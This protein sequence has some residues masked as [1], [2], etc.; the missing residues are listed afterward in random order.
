MVGLLLWLP[1]ELEIDTQREIFEVRWQGIFD[2]RLL[3]DEG[4]W[5]REMRLFGWKTNWKTN[6]KTVAPAQKKQP[7]PSSKKRRPPFSLRQGR[8]LVRQLWRAVRVRY[9]RINWDTDD[10]LLNAWLYPLCPLLS[11]ERRQVSINFLGQHEVAILLQTRPGLLAWA[12][13]RAFFHTK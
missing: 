5:R 1:I 6:V 11:G 9:F 12:A 7:K 8:V 13:L 10:F 3:P 2:F 4:R